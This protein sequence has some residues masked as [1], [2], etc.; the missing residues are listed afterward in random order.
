[1][2]PFKQVFCPA[3]SETVIE[4]FRT[5]TTSDRPIRFLS[6]QIF[7]Y[8]KPLVL[9]SPMKSLRSR[10]RSSLIHRP[11]IGYVQT[12]ASSNSLQVYDAQMDF[13]AGY[14][15]RHMDPYTGTNMTVSSLW[16]LQ[17]SQSSLATPLGR[18]V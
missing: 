6:V 8:S 17:R 7:A 1:M 12:K 5:R 18:K 4:L 14:E 11:D 15:N 2:I 9:L 10:L 16:I 13:L 3:N